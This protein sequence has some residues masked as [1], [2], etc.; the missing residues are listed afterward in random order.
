[1]PVIITN[2]NQITTRALICQYARRMTTGQRLAEII[3]AFCADALS[4]AV[5][6]NADL[7]VVLYVLVQALLAAFRT[8]RPRLRHRHTRRVEVTLTQHPVCALQ[9]GVP[10]GRVRE[11]GKAPPA[12]P[13]LGGVAAAW[14]LIRCVCD[15]QRC[16]EPGWCRV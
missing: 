7:D 14:N 15:G 10:R 13:R 11:R 8:A 4:S 12:L 1:M 3:G 9:F 5:N 16:G 6:L 2:D